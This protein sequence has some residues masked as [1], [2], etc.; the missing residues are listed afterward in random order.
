MRCEGK[1]S[2]SRIVSDDFVNPPATGVTLRA[3]RKIRMTSKRSS[4]PVA[5]SERVINVLN[6]ILEPASLNNIKCGIT[7]NVFPVSPLRP[8]LQHRIRRQHLP[9]LPFNVHLLPL[10]LFPFDV[11]HISQVYSSCPPLRRRQRLLQPLDCLHRVRK[12]LSEIPP[13]PLPRGRKFGHRTPTL[14][15]DPELQRA[16]QIATQ[17]L[18]AVPDGRWQ[19]VDEAAR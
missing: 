11:A 2:K 7:R 3:E 16:V 6:S 4:S 9:I 1:P 5:N 8:P 15:P 13:A 14:A 12:A 17:H 18:E 10:G 19:R